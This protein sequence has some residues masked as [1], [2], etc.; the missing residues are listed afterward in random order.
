MGFSCVKPTREA[1]F[2]QASLVERIYMRAPPGFG[3]VGPSIFSGIFSVFTEIR[4]LSGVFSIFSVYFHLFRRHFRH[5][6]V[7]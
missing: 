4:I 7:E 3:S 1:A 6:S 2:L 5:N